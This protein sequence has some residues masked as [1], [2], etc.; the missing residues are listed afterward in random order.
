MPTK[1]DFKKTIFFVVGYIPLAFIIRGIY[2]LLP[3]LD[4]FYS[5]GI[6]VIGM[7]AIYYFGWKK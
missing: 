2:E 5:I 4:P 6:G 1:D 3:E 7:Y